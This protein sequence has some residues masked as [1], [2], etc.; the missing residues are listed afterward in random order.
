ML[1]THCD[2]CLNSE[3][4]DRT[5]TT[6]GNPQDGNPYGFCEK[7]PKEL[8]LGA[9]LFPGAHFLGRFLRWGL[10]ASGLWLLSNAAVVMSRGA[11]LAEFQGP[12]TA[13]LYPNTSVSGNGY[14][15]GG[16]RILSGTAPATGD[17]AETGTLGINWAL[18]NPAF[19][20]PAAAT[21]TSC[22]ANAMSNVSAAATITAGYGRMV[23]NADTFGLSTVFRRYQFGVGTSG[24]DMNFNTLAI[25]AGGTC[26]LTSLTITHG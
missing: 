26:S 1:V 2:R 10:A 23:E 13:M 22:T 7:L 19:A 18:P 12:T 5:A 15:A 4:C 9:A 21:P 6:P 25:S 24:A 17:A 20:A 16:V 11:Q 3:H 14:N 8:T